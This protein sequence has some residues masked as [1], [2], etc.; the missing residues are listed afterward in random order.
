MRNKR[1]LN[2]EI[3]PT[4]PSTKTDVFLAENTSAR[5]SLLRKENI[6]N[7]SSMKIKIKLKGDEFLNT[8]MILSG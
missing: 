7:P 4:L 2:E 3:A 1:G 8:L 5:A 6:P